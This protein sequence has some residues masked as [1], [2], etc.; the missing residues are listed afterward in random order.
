MTGLITDYELELFPPHCQPE[1]PLC[2][3]EKYLEFYRKLS[4]MPGL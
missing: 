4:V 2:A 3:E 1:T